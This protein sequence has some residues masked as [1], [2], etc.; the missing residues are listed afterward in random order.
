VVRRPGDHRLVDD[1]WLNEGLPPGWIQS[2][3]AVEAEWNTGS[4]AEYALGPWTRTAWCPRVQIRQPIKSKDDIANAFDNITYSKG[5]AVIGMFEGW[6]GEAAFQK[7]CS[8]TVRT[9]LLA[10]RDRPHFLD[11]SGDG[12]GRGYWPGFLHV[13]RSAGRS[14]GFGKAE[15]RRRPATLHLSQK[16]ALSVG[17]TGRR[18][19]LA[20]PR[21]RRY[22]EGEAAHRAA[23]CSPRRH[24]WKLPKEPLARPGYW[25]NAEGAGY[26]RARY[27]GGLLAPLL[28]D[29][30]PS[31]TGER[32]AALG[33]VNLTTMA[34][35]AATPGLAPEFARRSDSPGGRLGHR[36]RHQRT[37]QPGPSGLMPN[38]ARFIEKTSAA[39]PSTGFVIAKRGEDANAVAASRIVPLVAIRGTDPGWPR[40]RQLPNGAADRAP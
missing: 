22:G 31:V 36:R 28:A 7:A 21:L 10:Q 39:G 8:A 4:R 15:L 38:Y 11:S 24:D 37:R 23:R 6:M 3:A 32:V 33:D 40:G 9:I 27:E 12:G 16:R 5:E 19:V 18:G 1:I 35:P 34:N 26:Y 29:R 30:E 2:G 13:P 25:R 20:D 17:H 14:A